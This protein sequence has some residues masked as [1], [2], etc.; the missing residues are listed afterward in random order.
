MFVS[1]NPV[2]QLAFTVVAFFSMLTFMLSAWAFI[3]ERAFLS[4]IFSATVASICLLVAVNCGWGFHCDVQS[5]HGFE[6]I[7]CE[8]FFALSVLAA[9]SS[10]VYL[11]AHADDFIEN[12]FCIEVGATLLFFASIHFGA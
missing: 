8:A 3:R 10:L 12:V 9:V 1:G 4:A 11:L 7:F 6:R 2:A 5:S